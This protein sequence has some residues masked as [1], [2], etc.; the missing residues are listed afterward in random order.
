MTALDRKLRRDIWRLRGQVIAIALIVASGVGVLIM[1]LSSLEALRE[2]AEAYYERYRFAQVFAEVKRAP[3]SLERKIAALPGI[4]AVETRIAEFAVVDVEG[5]REP[6]I[7]QFVSVPERGQPVLNR[8]A[9][10]SGRWIA[11]DRVDEVIIGEPFAEAHGLVPGDTLQA[12]LR[13]NKRTLTVVGTALSPEFVY[14]IGP[15]ALMPDEERFGIFWM[16]RDALAAAYDLEDSFNNVALSLLRGTDP[17]AVLDRLDH[18]LEDYG[19]VG[20]YARKD[21]VSNWFI[22]NELEQLRSMSRI[23][24]TVF[25]AVAGFLTNIVL[26][27]LIAIERSEIGLI[28]AFGYSNLAVGWHYA[29]LAMVMAGLGVLLGWA[30]GYGLGQINTQVYADQFRFP[31]LLFR[32]GPSSFAIA[33]AVSLVAALIGAASAVRS[34][35][36]L[37][38]AEAMRPP[39]PPVFQRGALSESRAGRFLDQPS[40]MIFRQILRWPLRAFLTA[41]GIA[42]AVAVLISTLQWFDSIDHMAEVNFFQSQHQDATIGLVEAEHQSVMR[43]FANLPGVLAIEPQRIVTAVFRSGTRRHRGSING[44][45]RNAQLQPI[46]D[47]AGRVVPVPQSGLVISNMLAEKLDVEPGDKLWVE[48]LEGRRPTLQIQVT[49]LFDTFLGMP[50]YMEIEALNRH[51]LEPR[52]AQ[53]FDIL[54]DEAEQDALFVEL[55]ELPEVSAVMLRRAA[56]ETFHDTLA[57]TLMIFVSFFAAFACALAFGVV[58]NTARIAL[59]E[60]GRELAT[61]RV[62]GFSRW[63]I[64]YILLGEVALTVCIGLPLGCLAGFGLTWLITSGFETELFRV[65]LVIEP[66]TFG[67]AILLVLLAAVVSGL[68]VRDRL[69][70][71]DLI[72]VLKTRE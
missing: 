69:D 44:I 68:L 19:G 5:F 43:E 21:Q 60:R 35:V 58:Y 67:L 55:K 42:M 37:S 30:I 40:R 57:R 63:E 62:L 64:S 25:L 54:I 38:P 11:P 24:P 4:Q 8:L 56:V 39:A 70:S 45:E 6:I 9:L 32:P 48:I 28:K 18:L 22:M 41:S 52:R 3:R 72:A 17:A 34:A 16:G 13:G 49:A 1:S 26:A 65:P 20:A 46:Y 29:K 53:F 2:T 50:A 14:A 59:S 51:L 15:G 10:R 33:A 23:L 36:T 27:R 47:S 7:G 66:A 71:L 31:F 12:V 61:L